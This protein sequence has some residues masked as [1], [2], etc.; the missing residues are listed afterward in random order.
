MHQQ[1]WQ[2]LSGAF[3][4]QGQLGPFNFAIA[5]AEQRAE[6]PDDWPWILLT[7]RGFEDNEGLMPSLLNLSALKPDDRRVLF[8]QLGNA[9]QD[10]ETAPLSALLLAAVA[11]AAMARHLCQA[12]VLVHQGQK[13]WLRIFDG[14]VW[15]QLPR[16]LNAPAMIGLYGP[17]SLWASNLYGRWALMTPPTSNL[18]QHTAP[19]MDWERLLR[20]GAV[21]RAFAQTGCLDWESAI[22]RAAQVDGLV[23]RAQHLYQMGR[24]EDQVA[25]ACYGIRYGYQ[26]DSHPLVQR[27]IAG[28][29]AQS[30]EER[31][32]STLVD[33]LA[34]LTDEQWAV[35]QT[36]AIE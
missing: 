8:I 22:N 1:N 9:Q 7:P 31:E 34:L 36:S 5:S 18:A 23:Q 14:R 21:N 26:F 10:D 24:L 16:V 32:D 12:Q 33:C 25:F 27:E 17:V 28:W 4:T 19:A 13:S 29:M 30:P 35:I 15:S 2:P 20:V 3:L 11:P 6:L